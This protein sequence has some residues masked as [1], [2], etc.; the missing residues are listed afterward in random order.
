MEVTMQRI[1]GIFVLLFSF[2]TLNNPSIAKSQTAD[3][4]DEPASLTQN[5]LVVFEAFMRSA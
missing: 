3:L 1:V 5:R 4:P 2:V